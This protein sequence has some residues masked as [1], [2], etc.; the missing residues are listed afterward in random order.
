MAYISSFTYCENVQIDYSPEGPRQQLINTLQILAPVA[1]PG[2]YSF[3]IVCSISDIGE[4]KYNV[5]RVLFKDDRDEIVNDTGDINFEAPEE[6]L[7]NNL[8]GM[9]F[10]LD[11]RNIVLKREGIHSTIVLFNGEELGTYKIMVKKA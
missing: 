2:N 11:M 6:Q 1:I 8:G 9:Q 7:K 3:T 10:N 4:S 5:L